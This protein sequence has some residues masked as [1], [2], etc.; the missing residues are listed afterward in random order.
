MP[1]IY[2]DGENIYQRDGQLILGKEGECCC[3]TTTGSTATTA[4]TATSGSSG[5][6]SGSGSGS[7]GSG[8]SGSSGSASSA[9]TGGRECENNE[10]CC[11]CQWTLAKGDPE[12]PL[13]SCPDGW[14]DLGD[15]CLLNGDL[16]NCNTCD[17]IGCC[18]LT[19]VDIGTVECPDDRILSYVLL[20]YQ[21]Q[22]CDGECR[23]DCC[24]FYSEPI[25]RTAEGD[26]PTGEDYAGDGGTGGVFCCPAGCSVLGVYDTPGNW[27][28]ICCCQGGCEC[29][30]YC[31]GSADCG[32]RALC[33]AMG[34]VF[35]GEPS[36]GCDC[37]YFVEDTSFLEGDCQIPQEIQDDP[38][39]VCQGS[40][41]TGIWELGCS[42]VQ[43]LSVMITGSGLDGTL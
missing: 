43:W 28:G 16:V 2:W 6:S 18:T 7:S 30:C 15:F 4:T 22:C 29:I 24:D 19:I 40:C 31:A 27:E 23:E 13:E 8:P 37:S 9:S 20:P 32:D 42:R 14:I 41:W 11:R 3:V 21:G 36:C 34:C 1:D 10:D 38:S 5:G 17:T 39:L 25:D 35:S 26:C 12:C 33:E